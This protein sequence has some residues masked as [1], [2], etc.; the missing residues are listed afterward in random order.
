V[1]QE[2]PA[3]YIPTMNDLLAVAPGVP[4]VSHTDITQARLRSRPK[5]GWRLELRGQE[6]KKDGQQALG[7]TFGVSHTI[8]L[9]APVSQKTVDGDAIVNYERG[10]VRVQ[11]IAGVSKF[12]N[13]VSTLVWDN[14][15]RYT[16]DTTRTNANRGPNQGRI[17]LAPDNTVMR[18]N[19]SLG[20]RLPRS[21]MLAATLSVSEGKQDDPFLPYTINSLLPQSSLDSL[22]AHSLDAR[23]RTVTQDYRLTGRP[24][25]SV[26]GVLRYHDDNIT[27]KTPELFFTGFSPTDASF[28]ASPEENSP[29]GSRRSTLG[30]DVNWNI[31]PWAGVSVLAEVTHRTRTDREVTDDKE[32]VLGGHFDLHP[33]DALSLSGG[34]RQGDRKEDA[35]DTQFMLD[36]GDKATLRRYD[37][38]N[39]RQSAADATLTYDFGPQLETTVDYTF[40]LNDYPDTQLG[41]QKSE[42]HLIIGDATYQ[43]TDRVELNLG[44]G[45]NKV[46]TRQAGQQSGTATLPATNW[47]ANLRDET[48]FVYSRDSWWAIPEKLKMEA[49]YTFT[50]AHGIYGLTNDPKSPLIPA[51]VDLPN[52][53]YRRHELM[54]ESSWTVQPQFDLTA[55]FGYDQYDVVD[56]AN[57]DIPLLGVTTTGATAVYLGDFLQS[58]VAHRYMLLMTRRF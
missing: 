48:V 14:P 53:L 11:A 50:R 51:G 30:T 43:L 47:W 10:A 45:Y 19:M 9:A 58:Y 35:F 57:T 18:G 31:A 16:N 1:N 22:P 7:A 3:N 6:R 23:M 36:S 12:T 46:D 26:W 21:S 54:L 8:E 55:R 15:K 17:D 42:E 41:L 28:T 40:T 20:L 37:V 24:L 2:N 44:Y 38:A 52:T 27:S 33:G 32:S 25:P 39:R 49:D 4:L 13:D 34:F 56:F 5:P 29:F